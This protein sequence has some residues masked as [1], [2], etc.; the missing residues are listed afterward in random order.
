MLPASIAM[1]LVT[2]V[3]AGFAS[4][5][6]G[7]SPG[8][9]LVPVISLTLG[10]NQHLSQVVSLMAQVP[11]TSLSGLSDYFRTGRGTPLRAVIFPAIGFTL[12][13]P[14][15]AL[16]AARF[17]DHEL[18]WTFVGYLLLLAL[19]S[20]IRGT[21]PGRRRRRLRNHSRRVGEASL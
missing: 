11:P 4:G 15:G 1:G 12:G 2:G 16:F 3:A 7:V 6:L 13:G 17:T 20:A 19:L 10:L 21:N 8:G 14:V 18:R 9:I 5:L